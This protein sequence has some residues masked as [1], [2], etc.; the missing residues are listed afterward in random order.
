[1]LQS[2]ESGKPQTIGEATAGM[3]EKEL[4]ANGPQF[5]SI[6]SDA[7]DLQSFLDKIPVGRGSTEAAKTLDTGLKAIMAKIDKYGG[8][9]PEIAQLRASVKDTQERLE[10]LTSRPELLAGREKGLHVAMSWGKAIQAAPMLATALTGADRAEGKAGELRELGKGAVNTVY[11]ADFKQGVG[12]KAGVVKFDLPAFPMSAYDPNLAPDQQQRIIEGPDVARD[13]AMDDHDPQLAQRALASEDVNKALG[14]DI[15]VPV[16]TAIIDGSLA[17]VMGKAEGVSNNRLDPMPVIKKADVEAH[18]KLK[19]QA[20][21]P[22]AK[23]TSKTDGPG[24]DAKFK[25]NFERALRE[26][27]Q[28]NPTPDPD[29]IETMTAKEFNSTF[30]RQIGEYTFVKTENGVGLQGKPTPPSTENPPPVELM[31][32]AEFKGVVR[33]AVDARKAIDRNLNTALEGKD[34]WQQRLITKLFNECAKNDGSFYEDALP[35]MQI[36]GDGTI[37]F[38]RPRPMDIPYGDP[39]MVKNLTEL[40]IADFL[41]G[42]IDRHQGNY[43]VHKKPDGKMGI[44]AIDGDLSWG[45]KLNTEPGTTTKYLTPG[46]GFGHALNLPKAIDSSMRDQIMSLKGQKLEDLK[47]KL[48]EK[49]G[50]SQIAAF[51]ER[52]AIL[53]K[54]VGDSSKCTIIKPDE[55]GTH[56][57]AKNTLEDP[58]SSYA[59][60]ELTLLSGYSENGIPIDPPPWG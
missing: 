26:T 6:M 51:E 41:S 27:T 9:R 2:V 56:P 45:D 24:F 31:S 32:L 16:S 39:D 58:K 21:V 38:E 47:A 10:I 11:I 57:A 25:A 5:K 20:L 59:A 22:F 12:T 7:H 53:Q 48:G 13:L 54:H 18:A 34:G 55:W 23:L 3:R 52:V 1:M 17:T 28:G 49:L 15:S 4:G 37:S 30:G 29:R 19:Q 46:A 40:Q 36:G 43:F 33:E 44:S 8:D 42:Q 35:T 14:F 60:R 50:A